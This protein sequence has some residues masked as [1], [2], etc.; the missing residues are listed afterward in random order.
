MKTNSI[1]SADPWIAVPGFFLISIWC[2]ACTLVPAVLSGIKHVDSNSIG[3]WL[4]LCL[5]SSIGILIAYGCY[6]FLRKMKFVKIEGTELVVRNIFATRARYD[7]ASVIAVR[8]SFVSIHYIVLND[9]T[10]IY[11]IV[12][13][14]YYYEQVFRGRTMDELENN[15]YAVINEAAIGNQ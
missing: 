9:N 8:S 11:F 3:Q 2:L 1:H 5:M 13:P 14:F 10:R 4:G 12:D 7:C 6:A 15:L